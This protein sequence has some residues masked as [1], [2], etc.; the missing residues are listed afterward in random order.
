MT[1]MNMTMMKILMMIMVVF[2]TIMKSIITI[3]TITITI[4]HPITIGRVSPTTHLRTMVQLQG[5]SADH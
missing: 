1:M 5:T 2:T 4:T 3:T